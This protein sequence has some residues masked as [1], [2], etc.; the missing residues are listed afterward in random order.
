VYCFGLVV[1]GKSVAAGAVKTGNGT[2]NR[3]EPEAFK[4]LAEKH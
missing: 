2:I 4:I 3:V 1:S